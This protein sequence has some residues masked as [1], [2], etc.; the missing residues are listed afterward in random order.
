MGKVLPTDNMLQLLKEICRSIT[1]MHQSAM[2]PVVV[3][4]SLCVVSLAKLRDSVDALTSSPLP[5]M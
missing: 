3:C 2:L 1:P 5:V 4:S